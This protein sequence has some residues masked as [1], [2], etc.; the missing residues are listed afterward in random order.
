MATQLL[1]AIMLSAPRENPSVHISYYR[2]R[3]R[4]RRR[5]VYPGTG[6][7]PRCVDFTGK[8]SFRELLALYSVAAVMVTNDSGPAHFASLCRLPTV[9]LF[10]PETPRL[11]SPI[12]DKHKDL[13]SNFACSPC[14]SVYNGKKSPCQENRCLMAISLRQCSKKCCCRSMMRRTLSAT[15]SRPKMP[16][17]E[18]ML[19]A[20]DEVSILPRLT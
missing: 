14:V 7:S 16:C 15:K 18:D 6:S 13:Y 8:T 20:L 11:Y 17:H 5:E 19:L 4:E 9:V 3:I 2:S 10:G 12:G 1:R